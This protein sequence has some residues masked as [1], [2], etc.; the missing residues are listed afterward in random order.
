[1]KCS[2]GVAGRYRINV[3]AIESPNTATLV[4]PGV[5][6]RTGVVTSTG[7]SGAINAALSTSGPGVGSA[8]FTPTGST[9]IVTTAAVAAVAVASG[10]IGTVSGRHRRI[11]CSTSHHTTVATATVAAHR[12]ANNSQPVVPVRSPLI[13]RNSGQCHR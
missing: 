10:S 13:T 4:S 12:S 3:H 2:P 11:G 1:M 6:G 9:L 8:L 5:R 7:T